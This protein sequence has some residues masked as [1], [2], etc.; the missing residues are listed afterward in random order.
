MASLA[1]SLALF[2]KQDVLK[3]SRKMVRET[4][5]TRKARGARTKRPGMMRCDVPL[6]TPTRTCNLPAHT[7][8]LV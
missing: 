3:R 6:H 8:D 1:D 7:C 5:A 2:L 4:H